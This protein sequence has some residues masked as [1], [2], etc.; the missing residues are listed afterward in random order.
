MNPLEQNPKARRIA[1]QVFWVVSL[2]VGAVQ[3]GFAAAQVEQPRALLVVLSVLPFI[4]AGIGY[5]AQANVS[6]A[7]IVAQPEQVILVDEHTEPPSNLDKLDFDRG[8]SDET[9]AYDTGSLLF[10]VAC[11]VVILV[12][13]VWLINA[14]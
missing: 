13:V 5:T 8:R 12:G 11:I 1:Y 3:V 7:P 9:G 2:L 4:G 14:L 10:A 6:A